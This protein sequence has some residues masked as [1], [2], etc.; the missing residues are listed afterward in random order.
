MYHKVRVTL[1]E[2]C[3]SNTLKLR[4]IFCA[5]YSHEPDSENPLSKNQTDF[6]VVLKDCLQEAFD[7]GRNYEKGNTNA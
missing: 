2:N 5:A 3:S 6:N 4:S 1:D 7:A